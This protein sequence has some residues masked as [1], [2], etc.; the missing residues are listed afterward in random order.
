MKKN[1]IDMLNGS[2]MRSIVLFALPLMVGNILQQLYNVADSIIVGQAIGQDALN[3]VGSTATVTNVYTAIAS[4]LAMGCLVVISQLFGAKRYDRMKTSIYTSLVA[5]IALGIIALI[6]A[7]STCGWV[8][9][10]TNVYMHEYRDQAEAYYLL[11]VLGLPGMYM[12]NVSNSAFNALGKSKVTLMFLLVSSVLNVGLDIWFVA[13][14]GWGV[15]GAAIATLI[16]QYLAAFLAFGTLLGY[17][18]KNFKTETKAALFD[19]TLLGRMAKIAIPS[20]LHMVIMSSGYVALMSL[21]N[22]FDS[23]IVSGYIAATKIDG[24]CIIPMV[25]LGNSLATFAGQNMG[26]KQFDRIPKGYKA[27]L[28]ANA[29]VAAF[30][31][32]VMIVFGKFFVSLFIKDAALNAAAV[33]AGKQYIVITG[34]FYIVMGSM[35]DTVSVLRGCGDVYM[36]VIAMIVNFTIRLI[37]AYV[38]V[39]VLGGPE[40]PNS[41][42]AVWWSNILGWIAGF[43]TAFLRYRSGKWRNMGVADK[44]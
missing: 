29:M 21:V 22:R 3:A 18:K 35:S 17:V 23:N 12:Y 11:Y 30:F 6:V 26:A 38:M 37:F 8:M 31:A 9:K 41:E 24:I 40:A 20:M 27:T 19:F 36:P 43:T 34:I 16:S 33:T 28:L 44:I 14:L 4:G 25:M 2:P 1:K 32:V 7:Y 10:I 39:A 42:L 5:I 15:E 13:G